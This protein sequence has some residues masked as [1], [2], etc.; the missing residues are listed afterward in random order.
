MRKL[1]LCLALVL[2]FAAHAEE[3]CDLVHQAATIAMKARQYDVS[4]KDLMER[5]NRIEHPVLRQLAE[6]AI[7]D[8]YKSRYYHDKE[9]KERAIQDYADQLYLVCLRAAKER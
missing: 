4:L 1:L 5:V 8:A 3:R 9:R 2:P 7:F 6:A